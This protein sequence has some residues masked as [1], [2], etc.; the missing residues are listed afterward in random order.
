MTTKFFTNDDGNTLFE[1]FKGVLGAN[2]GVIHHFDALVGYLRSSGYFK[3]RPLLEDVP[4]IRILVGINVDKLMAETQSKHQLFL[5]KKEET[6]EELLAMLIQDIQQSNYN[7]INEIGIIQFMEDCVS[8]KV[9]MKA[10]PTRNIHAKIYIFR[11]ENFNEHSL[12]K[13]VITG[14]S[15]FT[16]SGLG[17]RQHS[18]Y[19]FNVQLSDFDDVKFATD[20]FE[21][22]WAESVDILPVDIKDL[23]KKTYINDEYT[24]YQLYIKFLLEYFGTSIEYNPDLAGDLPQGFKKLT[25]QVDAVSDGYAKM[26]KHG[27]FIL[28]DVVGLGKTVVATL[29]MKRYW[30]YLFSKNHASKVLIVTPPAILPSW[31]ETLKK[32]EFSHYDIITTGSLAK[33]T[34]PEKYDLVIVD[35]AHKFRSDY[36]EM[37]QE[38]ERICKSKTRMQDEDGERINKKIILVSATPLNN[39]PDDIANLVYLFQNRRNSTLEIKNLESFF[40]PRAKEYKNLY[41]QQESVARY[42]TEVIYQE[43]R[44]AVVMPLTVRRTRRDLTENEQY[45]EDL[46]EQGISFPT[47]EKPRKLLYRLDESLETLYDETIGIIEKQLGYYRY[48]AIEFIDFVKYPQYSKKALLASTQLAKIM[49][50]LLLKRLDSSFF[51]FKKSLDKFTKATQAMITM[52]ENNRIYIA[53]KQNVSDYILEGREDELIDLMDKLIAQGRDVVQ[54]EKA[55]FDDVL[56]EHLRN[57]YHILSAL[58]AQWQQ[59]TADP[60]FDEFLKRMKDELFDEKIN[61]EKKLVV[62]SES[63]DTTGYLLENLK[64]NGFIKILSVNSSNRDT[65]KDIVKQNFD[66]NSAVRKN[67]FSIILTTEVLAEGVNLHRSNIIVNYDTPWNS[68][69]LLQRTGR[70]N[71]IGTV[72]KSIFIYNFFPTSQV[73]DGIELERKAKQKLHAFHTALGEDSQIYSEEESPESFGLFDKTAEEDKSE[74]LELLMELR[75][76]RISKPEEFEKIK[77]MPLRA[78]VGRRDDSRSQQ[79]VVYIRSRRRNGFYLAKQDGS[80]VQLSFLATARMFRA[81]EKERPVQLHDQHHEHVSKAMNFNLRAIDMQETFNITTRKVPPQESKAIGILQSLVKSVPEEHKVLINNG[82]ERIREGTF[83]ALHR[84]VNDMHK[85]A[86]KE[87]MSMDKYIEKNIE[88][89]A[90][91]DLSQRKKSTQIDYT[92]TAEIVLSESFI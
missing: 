50:I 36:T 57:D 21:K 34:E 19:E 64:A 18:N 14:S 31:E 69:R 27:G 28:A 3:V 42:K 77:K 91:F 76:F 65:L 1:K 83:A 67:D 62:F 24:P 43:I 53:P 40:A 82:I 52:F 58:N 6:K 30:F 47:V 32:F 74:E 85:Q 7:K 10:H 87:R 92:S 8:G 22:L 48:R 80:I 44:D 46:K 55:D 13:S 86:Q 54:C 17:T 79:T 59:V 70:V 33:I 15:N 37:Y 25:Y 26:M 56:L 63:T 75:K 20:E 81:G 88:I 12:V 66:E 89:L 29:I 45:G 9:I 41:K 16:D 90:G 39:K 51:A 72:A 49:K 73:N 61:R 68:T 5:T 38:L 84:S 11:P 2:M 35:E 78:R 60:K 23:K 4:H 71:R